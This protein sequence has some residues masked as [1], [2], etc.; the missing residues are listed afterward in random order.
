MDVVKLINELE[1]WIDSRKIVMGGLCSNFN[2]DEA[3]DLAQKIKAALPDDVKRADRLT[4]EKERVL[5][6]ARQT[7]EQTLEDA[8]GEAERIK[9]DAMAAAER[10]QHDAESYAERTR[11]MADTKAREL[12][13]NSK[14]KADKML[15]EAQKRSESLISESEVVRLATAHAHQVVSAAEHDAKDMRRGADEYAHGVLSDLGQHVGEIMNTVEK[16]R[17]KLDQRVQQGADRK[18]VA[19]S[20]GHA[21][22]E[23]A[24]SQR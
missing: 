18:S 4:R 10:L 6:G 24:G 1:T 14:S 2:K 8:Q 17:R 22:H 20:N 12:M 3:L 7:A 23:L 9:R 15:A 21:S 19:A 16:G 11:T 5:S 13:D